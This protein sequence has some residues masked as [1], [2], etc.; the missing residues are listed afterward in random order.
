MTF[1]LEALFEQFQYHRNRWSRS[2]HDLDMARYLYT[3]LKLYR[4]DSVDY[5]VSYTRTGP[6]QISHLSHLSTHPLLMLLSKHRVVVPAS[7]QSPKAERPS[8]SESGLQNSCKTS[9]TLQKT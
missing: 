9:G 1:T 2:N 8:K 5:I 4:H 7:E 6:F 3:T